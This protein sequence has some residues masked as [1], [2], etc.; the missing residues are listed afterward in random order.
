VAVAF[1]ACAWGT[2]GL[3]L[4]R[5]DAIGKMPVA[6]E[7]TIVMAVITIVT[8][9]TSVRDRARRPAPWRARAWVA[10]LGVSDAM[11][12]LLFFA[13]YKITIAISV[14]THYL[15]SSSPSPRPCSSRSR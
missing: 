14:L 1:A 13:A 9:L 3:I 8:G 5:T 11:N 6:L 2:W 10:W 4:R 12:I 15:T 7:S